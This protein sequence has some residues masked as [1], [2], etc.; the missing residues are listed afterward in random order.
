MPKDESVFSLA[1]SMA[2]AMISSSLLSIHVPDAG[3]VSALALTPDRPR[4]GY[5][6]AHGAGAGMTHAHM[7]AMAQ[8]LARRDVATLRFQFPFMEQGKKRTDPPAVA[9]AAVRAAVMAAGLRWPRLALFA[10]GKSFGGR[11]TSQAQA[12]QPLAGVL[13][14]AFIGF[15]LHPAGKPS[16]ARAAHLAHVRC[17]LLFLQ[18]TRDELADLELLRQ[19]LAPLGAGATL[20]LEHDADHAFHTRKSSGRNDGQV[21]ESMCDA[22]ATWFTDVHSRAQKDGA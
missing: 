16:T 20:H 3:E 13:G 15:P 10:G 4:F 19:A 21:I 18:G 1:N 22:M 2:F 11:M 8:A 7:E 14:L 9:Q 6:F 17:P 12:D 5:V